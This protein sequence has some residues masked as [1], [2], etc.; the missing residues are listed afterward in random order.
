MALSSLQQQQLWE[1][2]FAAEVRALYFADLSTMYRQRH[3]LVTWLTLFGSS[4]SL[5]AFLVTWVG[6]VWP[7]VP[8]VMAIPPAGL[9]LY[10][11]VA[12]NAQRAADS[13][14]LHARWNAL[15]RE[16]RRL[17]DDMY[18]DDARER[19]EALEEKGEE[20]SSLALASLPNQ[21]DRMLRWEEH[22]ERYYAA[23][24]VAV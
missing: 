18:A 15:A 23:R 5:V 16:R 20:F 9:S 8:A 24:P 12:D 22:V 7:W 6:S 19:F 10:A 21:E 3:R 11:L 1:G 17:W 2:W 4:G 13:R 14:E